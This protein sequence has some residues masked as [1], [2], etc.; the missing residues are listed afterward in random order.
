MDLGV[1]ALSL[2]SI[3]GSFSEARDLKLSGMLSST[4]IRGGQQMIAFGIAFV[5]PFRCRH[6]S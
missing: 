3:V 6:E 1:R 4:L 5:L 2:D